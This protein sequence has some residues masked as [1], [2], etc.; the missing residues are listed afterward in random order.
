MME[1]STKF[2]SIS[3]MSGVAA[4]I[5]ALL[6]ATAAWFVI[7]KHWRITHISLLADFILIAVCVLALA[8]GF[9]LLFSIRKARKSGSKFW[10]PVTRQILADFTIPMAAGGLFC[11]ALLWH[12]QWDL[13]QAATLV[14][15]GLAL[16]SAGARTY[17]DV[18]ILGICEIVLGIASAFI[19]RYGLYFWAFGFGVLHILYGIIM[20][21]RY[22]R[23]S[24]REA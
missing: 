4:G 18:K 15:Y 10:M 12:E 11:L 23:Q 24:N 6:G 13:A 9:G 17:K 22:D 5:A 3:G 21:Y 19:T 16:I 14:F 8:G 1:R 2:L 7:Y 20:Y